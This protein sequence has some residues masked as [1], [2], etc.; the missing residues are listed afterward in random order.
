MAIVVYY[1]RRAYNANER[2]YDRPNFV[3]QC[4]DF[5]APYEIA[6]NDD[7]MEVLIC[8]DL[9][10][11]EGRAWLLSCAMKEGREV[12]FCRDETAIIRG[13]KL[14]SNNTRRFAPRRVAPLTVDISER[15]FKGRYSSETWRAAV[16]GRAP[17]ATSSL[18]GGGAV[19]SRIS[20][21]KRCNAAL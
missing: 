11:G 12:P 3:L 7:E 19:P 8:C 17:T 2:Q 20:V 10:T 6:R 14:L 16:P 21:H 4:V 15:T 1:D 9:Y 13:A 18:V 5:W